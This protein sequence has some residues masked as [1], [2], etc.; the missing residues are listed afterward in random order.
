MIIVQTDEER[1]SD[2]AMEKAIEMAETN[3]DQA[4]SALV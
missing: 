1:L 4:D 2:Q 3:Q